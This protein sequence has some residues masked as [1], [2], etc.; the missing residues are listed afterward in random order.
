MGHSIRTASDSEAGDNYSFSFDTECLTFKGLTCFYSEIY[1]IVR[2]FDEIEDSLCVSQ[3][4]ESKTDERVILFLK[5][6][7][8]FALSDKLI[9]RLK[10]GIREQLSPRH[11]PALMLPI[12]DIPVRKCLSLPALTRPVCPFSTR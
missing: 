5:M 2:N 7:D 4:N 12:S 8:G 3:A 9:S 11:V 1:N 6:K 10:T